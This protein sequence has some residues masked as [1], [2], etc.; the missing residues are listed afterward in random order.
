MATTTSV[1]AE[2][3]VHDSQDSIGTVPDPTQS[4]RIAALKAAFP[5]TVPICMGFLFLG[6]SYGMLMGT[7]GFSFVWP[8]CMSAFIFAGSMEFVTVNLLLSAF[9][10]IAAF[11]LALMVNARHLFYGLSMLGPFKGLGWKRP[12]LIFGMC[13]ETFAI[14]SSA[15]IPNGVDRG[16]FYLWVTLF[17]Q[18]YWVIGATI[19]GLI[20]S[21]LDFNTDGLEFVLTALFLVIF[22]DQWLGGKHRERLS[23][24]IGVLASLACLVVFGSDDFMIPSLIAMLVLFMVLRPYLDTL[25]SDAADIADDGS[26]GNDTVANVRN[27]GD[28]PTATAAAETKEER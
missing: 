19:G 3:P 18:S 25:K 14:N 1:S 12:Y 22:L 6:A 27:A 20:G 17:N 28:Q 24:V 9:N 2:A 23:A 21:H 7:K 26:D 16:W 4:P 5:L 11:L 13:D 15:R 10:P 8:M